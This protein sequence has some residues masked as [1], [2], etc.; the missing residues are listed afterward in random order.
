MSALDYLQHNAGNVGTSLQNIG[1]SMQLAD[2]PEAWVVDNPGVG[3]SARF[4]ALDTSLVVAGA[5]LGAALDPHIAKLTKASGYG[6]ILGAVLA[7]TLASFIAAG[8]QGWRPA[9][10]VALGS[11]VALLPVGGALML[12]KDASGNTARVLLGA[13]ALVIGASYVSRKRAA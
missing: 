10:G 6:P 1:T 7:N 4:G 11:A 8:G 12:G 3:E 2:T 9:V 13:A 5:M